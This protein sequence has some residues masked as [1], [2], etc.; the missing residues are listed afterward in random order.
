MK[1]KKWYSM[2]IE[3]KIENIY[4]S[5]LWSNKIQIY[6]FVTAAKLFGGSHAN[7]EQLKD[8]ADIGYIRYIIDVSPASGQQHKR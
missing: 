6:F 2:E 8:L 5:I 3:K 1:Y 7:Q 4:I